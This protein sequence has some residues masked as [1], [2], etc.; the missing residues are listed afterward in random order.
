MHL[1]HL[2]S[3]PGAGQ[4]SSLLSLSRVG[5][6]PD[7]TPVSLLVEEVASRA[8][9]SGRRRESGRKRARRDTLEHTRKA[10]QKRHPFHCWSRLGVPASRT[11]PG[12]PKECSSL[13]P[14]S[15]KGGVKVV[16]LG[17]PEVVPGCLRAGCAKMVISSLLLGTSL[18]PSLLSGI[19]GYLPVSWGFLLAEERS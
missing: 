17:F 15:D 13:P 14:E 18:I 19:E 16:I 6:G 11:G 7:L 5:S 8:A 1:I 12:L 2:K 9:S 4:I 10:D 3:G